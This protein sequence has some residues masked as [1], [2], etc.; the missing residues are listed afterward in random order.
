MSSNYK[1]V[2]R[3]LLEKEAEEYSAEGFT[4]SSTALESFLEGKVRKTVIIGGKTVNQLEE[5]FGLAGIHI[6]LY[7]RNMLQSKDFTTLEG[8]QKVYLVIAQA[9]EL[10]HSET[11]TYRQIFA[12]AQE[13]GLKACPAEI[14]PHLRLAYKDQPKDE[15]LFIGM[16]PIADRGGIPYVFR[17]EHNED[18]LWLDSSW[19]DPDGRWYPQGRFVFCLRK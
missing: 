4:Q 7:A 16:K 13:L 6:S 18:G 9:R 15:V 12:G 10:A 11:L 2:S 1:E 8:P 5:K 19:A 14:G 3:G 17:L